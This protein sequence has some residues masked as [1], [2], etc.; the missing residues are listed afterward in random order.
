[1]R[2]GILEDFLVIDGRADGADDAFADARDDRRL[3]RTADI[4]VEVRAHGDPRFDV[5]L[6]AVL[7]DALEDRRLD[8]LRVDR[9]LQRFEDV[10]AGEVDRGGALPL[11][12]NL[13]ALRGDHR[14]HDLVDVAAGQDVRLQL[15]DGKRQARLARAHKSATMDAGRNAD[16]AHADQRADRERHAGRDRADPQPERKVVQEEDSAMRIATTRTTTKWRLTERS[17]L[18]EP[19]S[20][21][22]RKCARLRRE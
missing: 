14:Q 6:D 15:I 2:S 13:R 1:M 9:G 17:S 11:E 19:P 7:R 5:E 10:A 8:H 12:R 18:A 16:D 3:A 22:A 21:G 20:Q 4:A